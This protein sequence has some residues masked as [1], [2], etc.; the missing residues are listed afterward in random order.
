MIQVVFWD[1]GGVLV[2]TQDRLPR[3]HL[4][5]S[6]GLSYSELEELVWGGERGKLAQ[7]GKVTEEEQW[8]FACQEIGW[9]QD[10]AP[11]L[12]SLFFAGDFVDEDLANYIRNLRRQYKTGVIS[13]A[14]DGAR[15]FLVEE[16]KISN[17]FDSLT[18][19]YEVGIMKP[20]A[21]I[22]QAAL[23]SLQVSAQ[24]SVF[25]DDFE[26]NIL[27]AR[28]IGMQAILFRSPQQVVP[29]LQAVLR[30]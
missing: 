18:Y 14:M 30:D 29:D 27:G 21:Q 1:I 8:R 20:D 23:R 4:A 2:R 25:I 3:T 24:E 12:K 19:S 17:A 11:E 28:A 9:T 10:R 5:Q 15:R 26:H 22:F 7:I 16:A 13:N 6:V